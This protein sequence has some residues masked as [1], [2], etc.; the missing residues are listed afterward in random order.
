L[1]NYILAEFD[2]LINFQTICLPYL[3]IGVHNTVCYYFLQFK[4]KST[5]CWIG[6]SRYLVKYSTVIVFVN[7]MMS[8]II[9]GY[10]A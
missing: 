10:Y 9:S 2:M 8:I 4:K 6:P 3:V 5:I 1:R 7:V